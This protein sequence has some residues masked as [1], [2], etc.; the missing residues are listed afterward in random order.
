MT[1]PGI[2]IAQLTSKKLKKTSQNHSYYLLQLVLYKN[3]TQL[4][5][6][7]TGTKSPTLKTNAPLYLFPEKNKWGAKLKVSHTYLFHYQ[8]QNNYLHLTD[9]KIL[10]DQETVK[11]AWRLLKSLADNSKAKLIKP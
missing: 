7:L 8:K 4:Y 1:K 9:W 3:L 5:F 2:I 11:R 6:Q 10:G